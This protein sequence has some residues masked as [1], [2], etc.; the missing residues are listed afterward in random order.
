MGPCFYTKTDLDARMPALIWGKTS[1]ISGH[2]HIAPDSTPPFSSYDALGALVVYYLDTTIHPDLK[3]V[4]NDERLH[5]W[6]ANPGT[7]CWLTPDRPFPNDECEGFDRF[8]Y[9]MEL[10]LLAYSTINARVLRGEGIIER[11]NWRTIN[12]AWR[13]EDKTDGDPRCQAKTQGKHA[14]RTRAKSCFDT[15]E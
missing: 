6:I 11:Y 10:E 1:W 13:L 8:K 4:V 12:Y 15:G 2:R 9:G 7:L 3:V 14:H 5:F